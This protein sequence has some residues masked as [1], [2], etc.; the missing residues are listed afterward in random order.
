MAILADACMVS[1]EVKKMP[2]K[3]TIVGCEATRRFSVCSFAE[4]QQQLRDVLEVDEAA[5]PEITY[6]DED[7]DECIL[8]SPGEF[9]AALGACGDVLRINVSNPGARATERHVPKCGPW[10]GKGKGKGMML[11][12]KGACRLMMKGGCR[13]PPVLCVPPEIADP[14]CC[15]GFGTMP[16]GLAFGKGCHAWVL[17]GKGKG[18]NCKG[19]GKGK[20][21]PGEECT[22]HDEEI[23]RRLEAAAGRALRERKLA[24]VMMRAGGR[25]EKAEK[26][27]AM[28]RA[29]REALREDCADKVAKLQEAFPGVSEERAQ[30]ALARAGGDVAGAGERLAQRAERISR[31][32]VLKTR[33]EEAGMEVPPRWVLAHDLRAAGGDVETA[34]AVVLSGPRH[35]WHGK[36]KGKGM[37]P[38]ELHL[39]MHKGKGKG[40][41][42]GK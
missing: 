29:A 42:K 1:C 8:S 27:L 21:F 6:T 12:M 9:D 31:L 13:H 39:R 18:W 25:V 4:L 36:G 30:C 37:H 2:V 3:V 32:E 35:G 16:R 41:G 17:H 22:M 28:R 26:W 19:K 33:I 20:G 38:A 11:M 15:G 5:L 10:R 7:G 23:V 14:P 34:L 40:K 24:R